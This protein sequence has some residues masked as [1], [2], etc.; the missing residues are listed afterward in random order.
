MMFSWRLSFSLFLCLLTPQFILGRE[1]V[2][3]DPLFKWSAPL[4]QTV[5]EISALFQIPDASGNR[6]PVYKESSNAEKTAI[7]FIFEGA[8]KG[9][10]FDF[11][12]GKKALR[13]AFARISFYKPRGAI[14]IL[15][16]L[17]DSIEDN[18]TI[19]DLIEE[20]GTATGALGAEYGVFLQGKPV[21]YVPA[22]RW[23]LAET[24]IDMAQSP[25]GRL[26]INI[27]KNDSAALPELVPSAL[28]LGKIVHLKADL[29]HLLDFSKIWELDIPQFEKLYSVRSDP[30]EKP[31]Q[32]EWLSQA[33]D[34]ARFSRRMF[35]D[36]QTNLTLFGRSQTVEEATV[37]FVN[38]KPARAN[39][40]IYN[41]GDSGTIQPAAFDALIKR[42]GK[43]L[44]EAL[45]V[46]PRRQIQSGNAAVKI[47]SWI[48]TAPTG[49]AIMEHNDFN[50]ADQ[51]ASG[52]FLRV[53][54]AAPN[55]ADWSTGRMS[56][57]VQRMQIQKNVTKSGEGDV[58]ISGVPMVDQGAK[59]YCV[60]ASCQRLFE[61]MRIPCDQHEL[62]LILNVDAEK[63]ADAFM[64]QQSLSKVDT[65]FGVTFKPLVNPIQYYSTT[66]KRRVS[67]SEFA[68][69]IREHTDKGIPLLWALE[70]GKFNETPPLPM[71]GQVRGGHMRMIIGYN[72]IKNE[73]LF[74]DSWGAGHELKRMAATDAWEATLGLYLMIPRGLN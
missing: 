11:Y 28:K 61:Y 52:E 31:P 35:S 30:Q 42:T 74:T 55:Q 13:V 6:R 66:G 40:S 19:Q 57:G 33:K 1:A 69:E 23:S 39:I 65:K 63:G 45:K 67:L 60:A 7:S 48:W 8:G 38:G 18:A 5:E 36:Q 14:E 17:D 47:V 49:V 27:H 73:V 29:D 41:R 51:K 34:K 58:F 43:A 32:F 2:S 10:E 4:T 44:G 70:L 9:A 16:S 72:R 68:D 15:A 62:A 59:G 20:I 71:G 64:M 26:Y 46:T 50:M 56:M 54:L 22:V 12:F 53:K 3:L 24:T 21:S 25:Q 37:E